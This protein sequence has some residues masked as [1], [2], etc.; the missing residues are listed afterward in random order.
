MCNMNN[1]GPGIEPWWTPLVFF[2]FKFWLSNR[3]FF[4]HHRWIYIITCSSKWL[5]A[6][7]L[8]ILQAHLSRWRS[9]RASNKDESLCSCFKEIYYTISN[10]VCSHLPEQ[11]GTLPASRSA[12]G[13]S[14]ESQFSDWWCRMTAI[15]AGK[16]KLNTAASTM[17]TKEETW[18]HSWSLNVYDQRLNLPPFP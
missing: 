14:A 5:E 13:Q 8:T 3:F 2:K 16:H 12:T 17:V 11:T 18:H 10:V 9:R 1:A 4:R 6:N 7:W 15:Q